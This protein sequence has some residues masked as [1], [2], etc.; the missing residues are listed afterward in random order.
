MRE[1]KSRIYRYLC[2]LFK[3][4]H[5][6][7]N[8]NKTNF[9]LKNW[10]SCPRSFWPPT[11]ISLLT[12]DPNLASNIVEIC[13]TA[14]TYLWIY[15]NFSFFAG[16]LFLPSDLLHPISKAKRNLYGKLTNKW[17][18]PCIGKFRQSRPLLT[19]R[20]SGQEH[21]RPKPKK[22]SWYCI[23]VYKRIIKS[24]IKKNIHFTK[25]QLVK[26]F[27]FWRK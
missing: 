15:Y 14:A 10:K 20:Q 6:I 18:K 16:K 25:F 23:R 21:L 5:R 7:T 27:S 17:W 1:N 24:W 3:F 8:F 2:Q 13:K 12:S 19:Y 22:V 26:A 4:F 11:Q 9:L